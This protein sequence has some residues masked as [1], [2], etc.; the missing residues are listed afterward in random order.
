VSWGQKSPP[1]KRPIGQKAHKAGQPMGFSL[2]MKKKN[3]MRKI[4]SFLTQ[5][6]VLAIV[7]ELKASLTENC[8]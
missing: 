6:I 3:Y 8:T 4:Q 5:L 2:N 1:L 7:R